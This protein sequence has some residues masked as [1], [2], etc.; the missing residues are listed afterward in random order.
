MNRKYFYTSLCLS[1]IDFFVAG[2]ATLSTLTATYWFSISFLFYSRVQ[3]INS[4]SPSLHCSLTVSPT[5]TD[6]HT[7]KN[8][9]LL[10]LCKQ[11]WRTC[12]FSYWAGELDTIPSGHSRHLRRQILIPGVNWSTYSCPCAIRSPTTSILLPGLRAYFVTGV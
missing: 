7:N 9:I 12:L 1:F 6:T 8:I 4:L 11:Q 10:G 2:P 3:H 5:Y